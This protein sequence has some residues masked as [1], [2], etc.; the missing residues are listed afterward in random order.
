MALVIFT[1]DWGKYLS[2]YKQ[3]EVYW[4]I[5]IEIDMVI[6]CYYFFVLKEEFADFGRL[7]INRRNFILPVVTAHKFGNLL[8]Y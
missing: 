4:F 5:T 8:F 2:G 6:N 1:S 7:C 3:L